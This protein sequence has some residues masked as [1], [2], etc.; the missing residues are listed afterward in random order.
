MPCQGPRIPLSI[1]V[2]RWPPLPH[3]PYRQS[4]PSLLLPRPKGGPRPRRRITRQRPRVLLLRRLFFRLRS[5]HC[6]RP[7]HPRRDPRRYKTQTRPY[8][9]LHVPNPIA[10]YPHRPTRIHQRI[11]HRRLAQSRPHLRKCQLRPPLSHHARTR[12]ATTRAAASQ[13]HSRCS[14]I[15]AQFSPSSIPRAHTK[16][17]H[18]RSLS[19]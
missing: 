7:A 18:P 17:R 9:R 10:S 5:Q 3:S 14:S 2:H 8:R 1:H 11:W 6:P 12:T 13:R 4:S 16:S 19:S 15:S